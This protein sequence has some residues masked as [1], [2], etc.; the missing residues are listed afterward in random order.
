MTL[1]L[2]FGISVGVGSAAA[3][4]GDDLGKATYDRWCAGCH[5]V[6]G[7][8]TGS[9]SD[10]MLPRPR[11]F[12][13]ALYQVRSTAS[14]GL[15]T[16]EDLLYVID[17]G[18]PG[19]TMPGWEDVLSREERDAL[20]L[21]VKTFSR[22]FSPDEQPEP[23]D[24]GRATRANDE[25]LAEGRAQYEAIECWR[26]HGDQGR[27]DGESS[28]TLAD[29]DDFPIRAADLTENW[30]FNGGGSVED[31]YRRLRTGMDGTPM[32]NFSD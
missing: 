16:D 3:Q 10:Y 32:P 18:M 14:G 26:C 24:F 21:Y 5:G 11:D 25:V 22:F 30:R 27:G 1:M 9:G 7:S 6:D 15:P 29:D 13:Q 12:S 17:N 4:S 19:S 2:L 20:V 31:I 8:G 28:S 23:L